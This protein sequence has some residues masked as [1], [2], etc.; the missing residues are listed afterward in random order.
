MAG[1]DIKDVLCVIL[2]GAGKDT[3]SVNG[4][5]KCFATLNYRQIY[6]YTLDCARDVGARNIVVACNSTD[7]GDVHRYDSKVDLLESEKSIILAER[8]VQAHEYAKNMHPGCRLL[9]LYADHC[10]PT[11]K[12][13]EDALSRA[14]LDESGV[15]LPVVPSTYQSSYRKFYS[16]KFFHC[17]EYKWAHTGIVLAEPSKVNLA[18]LDDITSVRKPFQLGLLNT[19]VTLPRIALIVSRRLGPEYLYLLKDESLAC[20]CD[21]LDLPSAASSFAQKIPVAVSKDV[22]TRLFATPIQLLAT[23]YGELSLE[24]DLAKYL[25]P[26]EANYRRIKERIAVEHELLDRV[27]AYSHKLN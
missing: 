14:D 4:R 12:G 7:A 25:E 20:L 9:V 10:F 5:S 13:L 2:A 26:F 16:P 15:V 1:I 22:G 23:P 27:G 8:L 3:S 11:K 19:M 6:E 24:V 18:C 17:R 21:F